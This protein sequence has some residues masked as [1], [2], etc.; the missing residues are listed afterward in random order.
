MSLLGIIVQLILV[1]GHWPTEI[2]IKVIFLFLLNR[3]IQWMT[4][5]ILK[6]V[7]VCA[8]SL[9]LNQVFRQIGVAITSIV[10]MFVCMDVCMYLCIYYNF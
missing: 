9:I 7:S 3:G 10:Y 6:N 4:L 1:P 5:Y 2:M 8:P